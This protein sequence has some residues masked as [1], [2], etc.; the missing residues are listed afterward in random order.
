MRD[1]RIRDLAGTGPESEIGKY[2]IM[3]VGKAGRVVVHREHGPT[4]ADSISLP[5]DGHLEPEAPQ[6]RR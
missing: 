1:S 3:P 4:P 5:F 2:V 6:H